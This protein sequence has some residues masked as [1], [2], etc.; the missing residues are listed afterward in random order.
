MLISMFVYVKHAHMH[1]YMHDLVY[2]SVQ[3][4]LAV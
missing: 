3:Y 2:A 1:A 4:M